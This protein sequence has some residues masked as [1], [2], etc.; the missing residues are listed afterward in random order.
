MKSAID[1]RGV[2]WHQV[3]R[4]I[5]PSLRDILQKEGLWEDVRQ[6]VAFAVWLCEDGGVD[7]Q[8]ASNLSQRVIYRALTQM[9]FQRP[10]WD[11]KAISW[12]VPVQCRGMIRESIQPQQ[13]ALPEIDGEKFRA[14]LRR[15][16]IQKHGRK[17]WAKIWAW[18]HSKNNEIP[19]EVADILKSVIAG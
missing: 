2:A 10:R 5:P 11:R 6:E 9:G 12:I 13:E 4:M 8:Y 3:C 1:Y 14:D 16:I 18:A 17:A 15:F 7:L 19:Q